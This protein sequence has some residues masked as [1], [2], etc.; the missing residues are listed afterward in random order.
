MT[1]GIVF[2]IKR[3][4][5]HD[6][7]GIRTTVFLKG[8]PAKCW[9]CH[10]PESQTI[11]SELIEKSSEPDDD[12]WYFEVSPSAFYRLTERHILRLLYSY[13]QQNA[14]DLEGDRRTERQRIW[15]QLDFNFPKTW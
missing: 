11:D 9:W 3:Y 5:I 12:R 8:C 13:N 1:T 15:L 2:D 14:L 7:P 6:G 10:N 4:A